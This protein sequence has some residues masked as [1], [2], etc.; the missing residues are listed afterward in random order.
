MSI[1][2]SNFK[3]DEESLYLSE[4]TDK[5][6]L[7]LIDRVF[8]VVLE[9]SF[10]HGFPMSSYR[11]IT[12][13]GIS[14]LPISELLKIM[15]AQWDFRNFRKYEDSSETFSSRTVAVSTGFRILLG[16]PLVIGSTWMIG[17]APSSFKSLRRGLH[18][19]RLLPIHGRKYVA[20]K[21]KPNRCELGLLGGCNLSNFACKSIASFNFPLTSS[22]PVTYC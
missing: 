19:A 1:K 5:V 2:C 3:N 7:S 8:F 11:A 15:P 20:R 13:D 6:W 17:L 9:I 10:S 21:N 22:F 12:W 14:E 16:R 4:K 18:R